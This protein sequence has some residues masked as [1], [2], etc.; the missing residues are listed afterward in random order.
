MAGLQP[1]DVIV[2]FDGQPVTNADTLLDAI[3]SMPPGARAQ[4]T[5]IRDGQR[6]T[7]SLRLGSAES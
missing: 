1:G 7:A 4:L 3:R 6:R 2:K 5:F